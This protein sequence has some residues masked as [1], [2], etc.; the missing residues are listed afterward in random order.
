MPVSLYR[1]YFIRDGRAFVPEIAERDDDGAA[2]EKAKELLSNS[3]FGL[4]EI[5][6]DS[7]KVRVVERG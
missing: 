5:W 4:M 1:F 6:Q 3:M 7:R 2:V